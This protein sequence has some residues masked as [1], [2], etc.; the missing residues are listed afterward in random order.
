MKTSNEYYTFIKCQNSNDK[1][2]TFL[3]TFKNPHYTTKFD[4]MWKHYIFTGTTL[5]QSG[6]KGHIACLPQDMKKVFKIVYN[7]LTEEECTFKVARSKE[8]YK[9]LNDPHTS[10]TE[11]NKFITFYPENDS[12][13]RRII[14]KL[15]NTLSNFKAPTIFTDYQLPNYS[16][17]Q[18]RY[19]AFKELKKWDE[20]NKKFIDLMTLPN[21]TITEDNRDEEFKVPDS[22]TLPFF[23]SDSSWL[24]DTNELDNK[25]ISKYNFISIL[26][27]K[28]KGDVYLAN[29]KTKKVIIKSANPFVQNSITSSSA[30]QLL[31]NES[32]FLTILQNSGTVPKLL[33]RFTVNKVDF[34]V[35][36]Y[37][38]GVSLDAPI[39][40]KKKEE[41]IY[42]LCDTVYKL[43][44]RNI[45]IGDLTNSNFI[46]SNGTC[47][48]IDLE[49]LSFTYQNKY[50]EGYTPYYIPYNHSKTQLSQKEDIFSLAVSILAILIGNLP[51]YNSH[52][53]SNAIKAL[54]REIYVAS[55]IDTNNLELYLIVNYLLNLAKSDNLYAPEQIKNIQSKIKPLDK[56]ILKRSKYSCHKLIN[57]LNYN[58]NK[59]IDKISNKNLLDKNDFQ[60][61]W[62]QS[63]EFGSQISPLSIQHGVIGVNCALG[64]PAI[65]NLNKL[66]NIIQ[67]SLNFSYN[68]SY[69]FG[70]S[71][72]L[73]ELGYNYRK[74]TLTTKD[75]EKAI[76]TI[77]NSWNVTNTSI[78]FALGTAGKLY[79]LIFVLSLVKEG[80]MTVVKMKAKTLHDSLLKSVLNDQHASLSTTFD[81]IN[82]AHGLAG[83][84]YVLLMSA[85][86]FNDHKAFIVAKNKLKYIDNFLAQNLK[87]DSNFNNYMYFSWCEGISGIGDAL[88]R[89]QSILN[90][91]YKSIPLIY[92]CLIKNC[93]KLDGCWCHGRSSIINFLSDLFVR[94]NDTNVYHHIFMIS[95]YEISTALNFKNNTLKF[96]DE[97]GYLHT[98]DFGV[99]QVGIMKTIIDALSKKDRLFFLDTKQEQQLSPKFFSSSYKTK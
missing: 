67:N 35:T 59:L 43:H 3:S 62:W 23:K 49:Y 17:V 9:A 89:A 48:L 44:S 60:I 11:A 19:G 84:A 78:D 14:K 38:D 1:F 93:L 52:D 91:K 31:A 37:I 25:N 74:G 83:T 29:H 13:F 27:Q 86:M 99:G 34:N 2:T 95:L 98:I 15:A 32:Q 88:V 46:F 10:V 40:S 64:R 66:R 94:T 42:A 87:C 24:E 51:K 97:T 36:S 22:V 8:V 26:S 20:V 85:L 61:K 69:L 39:A 76:N 80:D 79:S 65:H 5:P 72:L 28:N 16:P 96:I 41:I 4:S 54:K 47:Y 90:N 57:I 70:S 45:V 6:W 55:S 30:K 63:N 18:F 68:D 77:I 58:Q 33:D 81:R 71:G 50:R 53:I 12:K 75:F 92:S 73:W 56:D 82:F 7:L 21:G